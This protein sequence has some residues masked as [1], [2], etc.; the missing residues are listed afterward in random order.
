MTRVLKNKPRLSRKIA[1]KLSNEFEI[2][3]T[4]LKRKIESIFT[5][6]REEIF[7]DGMESSFSKELVSTIKK[8]GD[9][10]IEILSELIDNRRIDIE[11]AEE[12]M[13]WLGHIDHPPTYNKRLWLLKQSLQH[14]SARV[15]D[16]ALLVLFTILFLR[17][18][19]TRSWDGF[20]LRSIPA[21]HRLAYGP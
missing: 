4:Q 10:V 7:E 15:R 12:A 5:K 9:P 11:T 3:Q 17:Y 1:E 16:G 20:C 14:A 8:Y 19:D 21:F 13:R 2:N 6:E 18:Y